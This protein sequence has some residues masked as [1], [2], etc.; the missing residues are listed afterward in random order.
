MQALTNEATYNELNSIESNCNNLNGYIK[1]I[2]HQYSK[3]F[4]VII[5]INNFYRNKIAG[6]QHFQYKTV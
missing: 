6:Q 3:F 2:F 4:A 1:E 5:T